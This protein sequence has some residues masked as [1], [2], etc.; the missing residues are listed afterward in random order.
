MIVDYHKLAASVSDEFHAYIGKVNS[1][2]QN[3]RCFLMIIGINENKSA[4]QSKLSSSSVKCVGKRLSHIMICL[5]EERGL[6]KSSFIRSQCKHNH[7]A[8]QRI[9]LTNT[10]QKRDKLIKLHR[11]ILRELSNKL[12]SA[13][14]EGED[15]QAAKLALHYDF[16]G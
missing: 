1:T 13:G 11:K 9:F 16:S 10:T 7:L 12:N 15:K 3:S 14:V 4:D 8:C 6:G 5:S 2:E